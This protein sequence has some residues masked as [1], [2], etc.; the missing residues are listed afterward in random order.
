MNSK[1]APLKKGDTIGIVSPSSPVLRHELESGIKFLEE[2]GFKVKYGK[3]IFS[4][5]RFLA[6][7]DDERANDI[8]DFFKDPDVKAIIASR[9][10]QGSQRLLPLL[11]YDVIKQ[12][13]KKLFGFS[14][15]TALQLGLF[16]MC[17]LIS[18]TGFTLTVHTNALVKKTLMFCLSDQRYNIFKGTQIYPGICQGLLLGGNLTLLTNLMGTP[19]LPDFHE[20]ILLLEDVGVEPYNVDGMLSQLAL[21]GIFD[22]VA[23]V[24]FGKFEKCKSKKLHQS[25]GTVE[26]V[27][28]EWSSTLKVPCIKDF[29]YGHGRQNSV[30]PIGDIVVLDAKNLCV[31]IHEHFR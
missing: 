8:M 29:S 13:P 17:G 12:N 18:Y 5:E 30:L 2:N 24:I 4:E 27:I 10:G 7:K 11:D 20:S 9:G 3:H 25:N 14:D 28:N 1:S 31:K 22:Q 26:D 21:A 6:G 15:T 16:K 19:Y 23:G